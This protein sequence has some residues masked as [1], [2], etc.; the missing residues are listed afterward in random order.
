MYGRPPGGPLSDP[1][2]GKSR[3]EGLGVSAG[4]IPSVVAVAL[5]AL[6]LYGLIT[7]SSPWIRFGSLALIVLAVGWVVGRWVRRRPKRRSLDETLRSR[8]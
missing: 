1:R 4:L 5:G 6:A 8:R 3:A 2:Q 7:A